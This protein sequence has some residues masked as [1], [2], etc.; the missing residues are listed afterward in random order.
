MKHAISMTI[1]FLLR[2]TVV[3][4]GE[5]GEVDKSWETGI[6][7]L[8]LSPDEVCN[9]CNSL[10]YIILFYRRNQLDNP[11]KFPLYISVNMALVSA[12]L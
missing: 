6:Q 10:V 12:D 3:S 5:Y 11:V 1:L 8:Y 9:I 7:S 4:F 2:M